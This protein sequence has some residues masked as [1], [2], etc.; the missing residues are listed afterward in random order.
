MSQISSSIYSNH[1]YIIRPARKNERLAI[2]LLLFDR[3]NNKLS[4]LLLILF[5]ICSLAF[6]MGTL[7]LLSSLILLPV[8]QHI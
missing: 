1:D 3:N 2:A 6:I 4:L 8:W 5:C 7:W